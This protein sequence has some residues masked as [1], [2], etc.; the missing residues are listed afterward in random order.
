MILPESEASHGEDRIME[1]RIIL[2]FL[3]GLA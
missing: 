1:D 3:C 2:L